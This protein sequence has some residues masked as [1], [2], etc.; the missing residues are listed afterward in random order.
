MNNH[1]RCIVL[2]YTQKPT[3]SSILREILENV[4]NLRSS[5]I[6]IYHRL[7][8]TRSLKQKKNNRNPK[9]IKSQKNGQTAPVFAQQHRV[10]TRKKDP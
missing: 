3:A 7:L 4:Y 8:L 2:K 10:R 5:K 1:L 6:L 9:Y